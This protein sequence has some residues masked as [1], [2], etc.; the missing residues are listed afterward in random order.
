MTNFLF[1]NTSYFGM[2]MCT[3]LSKAVFYSWNSYLLCYVFTCIA[4]AVTSYYLPSY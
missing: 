1:R 3:Y 4:A 2:H